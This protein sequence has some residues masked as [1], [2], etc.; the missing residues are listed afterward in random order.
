MLRYSALAR[1]AKPDEIA[2]VLAFCA[3]PKAS[4]LTGVDILCDGGVIAGMPLRDK[5]VHRG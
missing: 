4:Y 1:F 3:S 2:E 5:L